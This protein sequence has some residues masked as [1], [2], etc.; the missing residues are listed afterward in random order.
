[1]RVFFGCI[2]CENW[3][4]VVDLNGNNKT[5]KASDTKVR[6]MSSGSSVFMTNIGAPCVR[7]RIVRYPIGFL[8][9]LVLGL[10]TGRAFFFYYWLMEIMVFFLFGN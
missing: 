4:E 9:L 3:M 5:R 8:D 10:A 1:M 2:L 6:I 7:F